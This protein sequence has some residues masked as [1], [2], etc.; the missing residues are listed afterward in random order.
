MYSLFILCLD[1]TMSS[2]TSQLL[3]AARGLERSHHHPACS[4]AKTARARILSPRPCTTRA[5]VR[6]KDIQLDLRV[7][8]ATNKNLREAVKEGAFRQDSVLP[9]ERNSDRDS[10]AA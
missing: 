5:C 6:P 1:Y 10:A 4:K 7:V 9:P 2:G 8:A 3:R